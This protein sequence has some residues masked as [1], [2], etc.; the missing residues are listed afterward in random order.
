MLASSLHLPSSVGPQRVSGALLF[1]FIARHR[2]AS[3]DL[4]LDSRDWDGDV[5]FVWKYNHEFFKILYSVKSYSSSAGLQVKFKDPFNCLIH[6][7]HEAQ[8]SKR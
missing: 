1:P 4:W 6:L 2:E 8:S 3:R 7:K 5:I